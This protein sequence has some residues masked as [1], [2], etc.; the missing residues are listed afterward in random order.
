[1]RTLTNTGIM[2]ATALLAGCC[3]THPKGPAYGHEQEFR[4]LLEA[5]IPVQNWGYKIKDIRFNHDREK[6]LV[7]FDRQEVVFTDDGFHRYTA[8]MVDFNEQDKRT[9]A[10]PPG[11]IKTIIITFP[12]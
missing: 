2:A 5:S 11:A 10:L 1:M 7:I 6:A 3:A 9:G 8:Q 4:K 12:D